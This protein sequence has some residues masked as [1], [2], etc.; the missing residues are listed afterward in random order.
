MFYN[1]QPDT[2]ISKVNIYDQIYIGVMSTSQI[3]TNR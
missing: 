1:V 3:G 2:I